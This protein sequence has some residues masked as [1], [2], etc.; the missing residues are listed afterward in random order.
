MKIVNE[1]FIDT[2]KVIK[3][4]NDHGIPIYLAHSKQDDTIRLRAKISIALKPEYGFLLHLYEHLMFN[5]VVVGNN[6]LENSTEVYKF[7]KRY[8]LDVNAYTEID[9]ITVMVNVNRVKPLTESKYECA[10]EWIDTTKNFHLEEGMQLLYGLL[11]N[12]DLITDQAIEKEVS[13]VKSEMDTTREDLY[14]AQFTAYNFVYKD[15]VDVLGETKDFDRV[16]LEQ[17]KTVIKDLDSNLLN[18]EYIS[19]MIGCNLEEYNQLAYYIEKYLNFNYN[20]FNRTINGSVSE[21]INDSINYE[22]EPPSKLTSELSTIVYKYDFNSN[23]QLEQVAETLAYR[24]L[25]EHAICD[26]DYGIYNYVREIKTA[27]Y[28]A[29]PLI[30]TDYYNNLMDRN[31][32]KTLIDSNANTFKIPLVYYIPL[33]DSV[34][35]DDLIID[36]KEFISNLTISKEQYETALKSYINDWCNIAY[37]YPSTDSILRY[38]NLLYLFKNKCNLN[39]QYITECMNKIYDVNDFSYNKLLEY[40]DDFKSKVKIYKIEGNKDELQ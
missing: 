14:E 26:I 27:A 30:N 13:I 32:F 16:G 19:L 1:F 24:R 39:Q 7:A 9:G 34:I 15:C 22:L 35:I 33:N 4:E 5:K 17:V 12:R 20:Q 28:G 31:Y 3:M 37:T 11:F 38:E 10:I 40:L 2:K 36:I 6:I 29:Y 25:L 21:Y 8:N 23:M 18:K